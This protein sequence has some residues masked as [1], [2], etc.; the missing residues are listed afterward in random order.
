MILALFEDSFTRNSDALLAKRRARTRL[1]LSSSFVLASSTGPDADRPSTDGPFT[2]CASEGLVSSSDSKRSPER[3]SSTNTFDS[4]GMTKGQ[5]M[6]LVFAMDK[7]DGNG[8]EN[9]KHNE[10]SEFVFTYLDQNNSGTIEFIEFEKLLL[11]CRCCD[12]LSQDRL[13]AH[14]ATIARAD[15]MKADAHAILTYDLSNTQQHLLEEAV[16]C[17]DRMLVNAHAS[18][19]AYLNNLNQDFR[20]FGCCESQRLDNIALLV[21]VVHFGAMALGATAWMGVGF[22]LVFCFEVIIRIHSMQSLALF[23]DDPRGREHAMQNKVTFGCSVVGMFGSMLVIAEKCGANTNQERLWRAIQLAPLLR[24]FVT[25]AQFRHIMRAL[26]SGL[27]RIR[28]FVTLFLIVFYTFS[29]C[30]YYA[31]KDLDIERGGAFSEQLNFS[32]FGDSCLAM[33]QATSHSL[34]Q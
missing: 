34:M 28:S 12:K 10:M 30:A 26:L 9:R 22:N 7:D 19:D 3:E 8:Q 20:I 15:L 5:C 31:F 4:S 27:K 33:F 24:I 18:I 14:K 11:L 29:E 23:L 6:A 16:V 21:D 2:R 13:L 1:A 32:T 17:Q 25:N